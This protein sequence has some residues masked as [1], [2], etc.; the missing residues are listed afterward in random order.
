MLSQLG[1]NLQKIDRKGSQVVCERK[2]LESHSIY[3]IKQLSTAFHYKI[4]MVSECSLKYVMS[5]VLT[6]DYQLDIS[7]LDD[8]ERLLE[9]NGSQT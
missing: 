2:D 9:R 1:F 3:W 5:F 4:L 7:S 8:Q 6:S